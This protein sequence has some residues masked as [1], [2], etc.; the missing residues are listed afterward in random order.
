M[1]AP[2]QHTTLA[3]A[4]AA[5]TAVGLGA[6]E[7]LAVELGS[8]PGAAWTLQGAETRVGPSGPELAMLAEAPGASA[9]GLRLSFDGDRPADAS[10]GWST[11]IKGAYYRSADARYGAGSGS[12]KAPATGLT[13]TPG[14]GA[15][16]AP[17]QPLGDLTMEFWLKPTRAD[18][19]EIVF[20]WKASR[21]DGKATRAQQ[22]SCLIMRGRLSLG[23]IDFFSPPGGGAFTLSLQGTRPLVPGAWSHHLVRFDSRTGLVEY[24]MDGELEAT[25]YATST[26]RQAGDVYVPIPGASGR[27]ELAH[28]YTGLIDEF[29]M[30]PTLDSS[31]STRRFP[32]RGATAVSPILDL[33]ATNSAML[34]I[35][36]RTREPGEAA[37]HWSYR[38]ADSAAGWT[39]A[40]PG[41][42][43]FVPGPLPRAAR[44]RYLQLRLELYPDA[45]G[46]ATPSVSALS[47]RYEPDRAPPAPQGVVAIPG[48]SRITVR[49]RKV[50]EPDLAGYMVYYGTAPGDYFGAGAAEGPSPVLVADKDA[51][52]LALNGLDNGT[53][54]FIAVAA[55]D[56]AEPPHIGEHSREANARPA[57]VSP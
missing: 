51:T 42:T 10:G 57:R 2:F 43:P 30:S 32:A 44:G 24:L 46:E 13:L 40:S 27:L 48:D 34:A 22:V 54:Y 53:L 16:F 11:E 38:L 19:G 9:P 5:L 52:S 15:A 41:W 29:R 31:L 56:G 35:T 21:R 45:S 33:G 3:L 4:L 6:E 36:A 26:G 28:N 18:S 37:I 39:D 50:S 12:F 49:W 1:S 14:P 23:F 20:L 8:R 47:I 7:T 17:N 55:Y 25:R